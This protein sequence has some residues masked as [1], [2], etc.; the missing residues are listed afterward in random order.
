MKLT[1]EKTLLIFAIFA[2]LGW[3]F[4]SSHLALV[5]F[6]IILLMGIAFAGFAMVIGGLAVWEMFFRK[7]K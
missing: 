2:I 3:I 1:F 7:N 6:Y 4:D 5:P